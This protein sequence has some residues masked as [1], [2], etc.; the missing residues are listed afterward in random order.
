MAHWKDIIAE[1]LVPNDKLGSVIDTYIALG[2]ILEARGKVER[3]EYFDL[4]S[5]DSAVSAGMFKLG[6]FAFWGAHGHVIRPLWLQAT[7]SKSKTTIEDF[8]AEAI[9]CALTIAMPHRQDDYSQIRDT[10]REK[11]KK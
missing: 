4:K 3:G 7:Q 8:F 9:P 5:F 10:V 2:E 11:F 6:F 1:M